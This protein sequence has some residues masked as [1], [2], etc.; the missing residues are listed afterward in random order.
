VLSAWVRQ[1]CSV[2]SG[3]RLLSWAPAGRGAPLRGLPGEALSRG[4][5]AAARGD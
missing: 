2:A 4:R 1:S 3:V 5:R